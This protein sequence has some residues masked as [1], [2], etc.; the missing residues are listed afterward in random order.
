MHNFPGEYPKSFGHY[1]NPSFQEQLRIPL[2][3]AP[4]RGGDPRR[5]LRTQDVFGL[6]LEIAGVRNE[7][8]LDLEEG[9]H[10]VG[11]ARFRT[12]RKGK[13]KTLL[14]RS[15]GRH[16]LYD[17]EADPLEQSDVAARFPEVTAAH[18]ARIEQL[19][20]SL[21]ASGVPQRELSEAERERLRALG[22]LTD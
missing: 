8:S 16:F 11:E 15:D 14:R 2:I 18:A 3:I 17:L 7:P 19:T 10:Y 12:Y 21:A 13:W 1:G 22:Y 9:E 6:L 20:Q 5:F 4:A